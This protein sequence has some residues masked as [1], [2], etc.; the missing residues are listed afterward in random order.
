MK[1]IYYGV[2]LIPL[3]LVL[4]FFLIPENWP[5]G[6][7]RLGLIV[8]LAAAITI[9]CPLI[10]VAGLAL[11]GISIREHQSKLGPLSATAVALFPGLI[12]WF[13]ENVYQCR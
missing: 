10:T 12:F 1:R 8:D 6:E 9:S 3:F 5:K 7:T 13:V 11:V 2:C 4:I